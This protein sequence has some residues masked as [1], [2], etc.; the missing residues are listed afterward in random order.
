MSL[1][2]YIRAK[3]AGRGRGRLSGPSNENVDKGL[4]EIISG[5]RMQGGKM[6]SHGRGVG[7]HYERADVGG[8][9]SS[10]N[11]AT[12]S[13]REFGED[14][15]KAL[16]E[17]VASRG[18]LKPPKY[19]SSD[20]D[21]GLPPISGKNSRSGRE[22]G[23]SERQ[24]KTV[25][26]VVDTEVDPMT[27]SL[28]T[29]I[30]ARGIGDEVD[31]IVK[32]TGGGGR[33]KRNFE[34]MISSENGGGVAV[35]YELDFG[36]GPAKRQPKWPRGLNPYRAVGYLAEK[37][38][39]IELKIGSLMDGEEENRTTAGVVSLV[40]ESWKE[41]LTAAAKFELQKEFLIDPKVFKWVEDL[42]CELGLELEF[43]KAV[44][45][46]DPNQRQRWD[47][48]YVYVSTYQVGDKTY[49]G[50]STEEKFAALEA[51]RK[52]WEV[53]TN[54]KFPLTKYFLGDDCDQ[55]LEYN[56]LES[57]VYHVADVDL[58]K[59]ATDT[60][61]Q[62]ESILDNE[63]EAED[64]D[65]FPVESFTSVLKRDPVLNEKLKLAKQAEESRKKVEDDT[66]RNMPIRL[67]PTSPVRTTGNSVF[68]AGLQLRDPDTVEER[69][70]EMGFKQQ[71]DG[72]QTKMRGRGR[73]ARKRSDEQEDTGPGY[74]R[75][76]GRVPITY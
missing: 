35:S 14:V 3:M 34:D 7:C 19:S 1:D 65:T 39:V 27:S 20:R 21:D 42:A 38:M 62:Q 11:V 13:D 25:R 24:K 5:D 28:E 37:G 69:L 61:M 75:G 58:D 31:S 57:E 15:F 68:L 44:K 40:V 12:K 6:T 4:D 67:V 26:L 66:R 30:E 46:L 60:V 47:P 32:K 43:Q 51:A 56:F 33:R 48:S 17:V 29:V 45:T 76:H 16:D 9:L 49:E 18:I 23:G 41:R 22:N 71:Q 74:G 72:T 64:D 70:H 50:V 53:F 8:V 10:G 54:K 55:S 52:V 63:S 2:Q 36:E 73:G 59:P